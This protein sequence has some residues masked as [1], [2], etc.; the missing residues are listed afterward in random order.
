MIDRNKGQGTDRKGFGC[1]QFDIAYRHFYHENGTRWKILLLIPFVQPDR[2]G[3]RG[4]GGRGGNAIAIRV[5]DE[6]RMVQQLTGIGMSLEI[7]KRLDG[8]E[9]PIHNSDQRIKQ[10]LMYSF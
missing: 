6:R 10:A 4:W 5:P 7:I 8:K 2:V 1:P 9:Y 3:G